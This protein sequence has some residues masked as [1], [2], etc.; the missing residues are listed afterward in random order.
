MARLFFPLLLFIPLFLFAA[1]SP[2]PQYKEGTF[3]AYSEADDYG[4]ARTRVEISDNEI[5]DVELEEFTGKG[6]VLDFSTYPYQPTVEGVKVMRERFI[7][8]DSAEVDTYTGSTHSSEKYKDAVEKALQKAKE[9]PEE[10]I[11]TEHWDGT[12]MGTA[13]QENIRALAWVSIKDD[14]IIDVFFDEVDLETGEFFDWE[15]REHDILPEARR[16]MQ[17][18]IV[19]AGSLQVEKFSGATQSSALWL[20]AAAGALEKARIE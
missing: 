1:C 6:E 19:M 7:E 13:E 17:E 8:A 11:A 20:E 5:V 10:E 9:D 15:D 18:R 3:S 2:G 14:R 12:F 16:E 4:Y